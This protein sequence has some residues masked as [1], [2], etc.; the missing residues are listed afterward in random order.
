VSNGG[1]F[2][3]DIA[4]ALISFT[5]AAAILTVTPGLDTALV[6]RTA[7][8]EGNRPAMS[9]GAGII[10]GVLVW[11]VLAA[12][13]VGALLAISTAGRFL[14]QTCGGLYLLWL[15]SQMLRS[16]VRAGGNEVNTPP[17][18]GKA[19]TSVI[20][21]ASRRWFKRGLLTNLFNPKVGAFYVSFLPQFIP[22]GTN[23]LMFSVLLAGIHAVLGLTWFAM[24][25]IVGGPWSRILRRPTAVR[26]LDGLTGAVLIGFAI[27]FLLDRQ[28]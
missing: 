1:G 21:T 15:G 5:V 14:L 25:T 20:A 18:N 13:G 24:L 4:T 17:V 8:V 12:V 7:A 10:T 11:G 6:L 3:V 22:H 19:D 9:A 28:A 26:A 23:P 2:G 16:A 27:R